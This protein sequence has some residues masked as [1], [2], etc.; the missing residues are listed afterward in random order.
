MT[1]WKTIE[2]LRAIFIKKYINSDLQSELEKA[3]SEEYELRRDYNG[4]QI[5]ELLQ[6][7]DDACDEKAKQK[8]VV[9]IFSFK[10]N[11][12]EVGNTGTT[13]SDESIERLCLGRASEKSSKNIGNKGT[14]F[15]SLLN[16]A[17]WIEIHSKTRG[18]KFSEEFTQRLF[19]SYCDCKSKE[20]SPLID[21]QLK[22]WKKDYNFCFPIM[23][24]P[25]NINCDCKGFDTL[26][27]VKIKDENEK[28]ETSIKKQLEQPFY[29]SLL[30]LPNI[31]K[32]VIETH[33]NIKEYSKISESNKVLIEEKIGKQSSSIKEYFL[34]KNI[35]SI[36][37]KEA[38]LIIAIPHDDNYDFK[39]EKLY[40]Y[41]P[42]RNFTTPIHALVHAPFLTNNSRDDIP[43]NSEQTNRTI[44]REIF[45][46][47]K[48]VAEK[49]AL[50]NL[51]ELSIKM[52]TPLE[53]S[54]LWKYDSFNLKN[55]YFEILST[56]KI[57]PTVNKELIS[58]KDA[59]KMF[60][61][62]FPDE[63][64]GDNFSKLLKYLGENSK[65]IKEL[66]SFICYANL[67][68]SEKEL[69]EKIN[70]I[71]FNADIKTRV[72]LFLW[73]NKQ[74][75]F[76]NYLPKLLKD[77]NDSWILKDSD[78]YL[79]TDTSL[80]ELFK[81]LPWVKLCILQEDY[82]SEIIE[83]L[84]E[85]MMKDWEEASKNSPSGGNKRTLA[86]FSRTHFKIKF[87][88]QSNSEQIVSTIN[89]QIKELELE[90]SVSFIN[91]VFEKYGKNLKE[92]SELSKVKF[93]LPDRNNI[94]CPI[95]KLYLGNEYSNNYIAEKLFQETELKPLKRLDE[96]YKGE[97]KEEFIF[98][99]KTCGILQYPKI[100]AKSVLDNQNFEIFI[101]QTYVYN[102]DTS[103]KNIKY[104]N[105]KTIDNFEELI[106][107]LDTEEIKEWL[108][109]DAKLKRL[110]LDDEK[111]EECYLNQN[112]RWYPIYFPANTY[113]K[114]VLNNTAWIKLKGK[115][116]PPSKIIKYEKIGNKVEGYYG[117]SEQALIKYLGKEIVLDFKLDFKDSIVALPDEDIRFFLDELP[118]FDTGEISRKLYLDIIK[119][120]KDTIPKYDINNIKLLCKDGKFYPNTEIKYVARK[121]SKDEEKNGKFINIPSKQ[122][123]ETIKKWLG[124][125]RYKTSL[126]LKNYSCFEDIKKE[127]DRE[128]NEIKIAILCTIEENKT[129][130]DALKRIKIIP[131]T[132]IEV[133]DSERENRVF[134]LENYF[135]IED[136]DNK[137]LF[138]I[139]IPFNQSISSLRQIDEFS[140]SIVDIFKQALTLELDENLIEL[141]ISKN[142]DAKRKK[143]E[144][145]YGVD[146]W[147]SL[148]EKLYNQDYTNRQLIEFFKINGLGNDLLLQI[149][150]I[151]FLDNFLYPTDQDKYEI[152]SK[153]LKEI[154]KD[155]KDLNAYSEEIN[156]DI[157]SFFK[158]K[159][160]N[161]MRKSYEKY[162]INLYD[163]I[164]T[165]NLKDVSSFLD[166]IEKYNNFDVN[167]LR[168]KNSIYENIEEN[169]IRKFPI[170]KKENYKSVNIDEIY[171]SHV[172]K[173]ISKLNIEMSK[174]DNFILHH[175]EERSILYFEIPT[176]IYEKITKFL[177]KKK[178]EINNTFDDLEIKSS[179]VKTKL[180]KL[181]YKQNGTSSKRGKI[182]KSSLE[183]ELKTRQNEKSGELAEKI[184]FNELSKFYDNLIWHS[185]YS[186]KPSGR[187]N[188]PKGIVCDMWCYDLESEEYI[189]FEIKSSIN[190]FEMSI[191]EYKSMEENQDNYEVVLVNINT[192]EISRH[193]YS[194]LENLKE[195]NGYRFKFKQEKI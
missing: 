3:C 63:F 184:A 79:A 58:I 186:N 136:I 138:Y 189:Y 176:I 26:I 42:I 55:E 13:F 34:Y 180:T 5:L 181:E 108:C 51:K 23:N 15:R 188:P 130:I 187:N 158:S 46:F 50:Q 179:T 61:S 144:D 66:A 94:I 11:I 168:L 99:L 59:P 57:L 76:K 107:S 165:N 45:S 193:K 129:N 7:V 122:S 105:S 88:E 35:V 84:Q 192:G 29:T 21:K 112:S 128:I 140:V 69:S 132:E 194:E 123:I 127:F 114:F 27:R 145:L 98:F 2:E 81:E 48:E 164:K 174:F 167:E 139:K 49:I 47:V 43:D 60:D 72:K 101:Y 68:Y 16:D 9:V 91:W 10:N 64:Y 142:G 146:K 116:Y 155:I 183:Y 52:T 102:C 62:P 149:S 20:Y 141:L 90:K 143:I 44:F 172:E 117:I 96:I 41:F 106:R 32:I 100:A 125:E 191:N 85:T 33:S 65:F 74:K 151:N 67:S 80:S 73:W 87:I 40:C 17:E 103:I 104:L 159:I 14:G 163:E 78:V 8:E 53:E 120:K 195:V 113:I 150:N 124:V 93:R 166:K 37:K 154:S 156:I 24:C 171:N 54:K 83:Q 177:S 182:E 30:F 56:A 4:R 82:V 162:R 95:D 71:S 190:E 97:R 22:N 169:L 110:I 31:T 77:S 92:G 147:S 118:N 134:F 75:E 18:L 148:C 25:E 28:K 39:S 126:R 86:T 111:D 6:N 119:F 152:L 161:I 109:G 153:A 135:F 131:S 175:N 1:K 173:I 137:K 185:K 36:G 170:L 89:Q 178:T 133:S 121:I 12:L 115:K 19:N 70:N 157:T 38:Q 160:E